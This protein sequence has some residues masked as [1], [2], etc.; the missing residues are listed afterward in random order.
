[1]A[2]IALGAAIGTFIG[3]VLGA[4]CGIRAEQDPTE[5]TIAVAAEADVDAL[6][7]QGAVNSTGIGPR[8]YLIAVGEIGVGP[9]PPTLP[10]HPSSAAGAA[11]V[12]GGRASTPPLGNWPI[13]G[14]LGEI[15]YC[16]E[17]VNGHRGDAYNPVGLWLDGRIQHAQG[18]LDWMPSTAARA[19]AIIGN[20]VSEWNAAARLIQ[21]GYG[22]LFW[23]IQT[24]RCR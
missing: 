2:R 17:G 11:P 15:L 10:A 14:H 22:Y 19:G 8:E 6:D 13:G 7:L 20:R 3:V 24:G 12:A 1:M 21:A 5:E 4:A 16:Q 18:F 23:G 9:S